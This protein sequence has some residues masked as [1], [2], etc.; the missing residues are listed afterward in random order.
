[1]WLTPGRPSL[2]SSSDIWNWPQPKEVSLG[3]KEIFFSF[4]RGQVINGNDT[5]FFWILQFCWRIVCVQHCVNFCCTTKSFSYTYAH[6]H[7]FSESFPKQVITEYWVE[8]P[9]LCI[10]KSLLTTHSACNSVHMPTPSSQSLPLG[11][12]EFI[13]NIWE[14]VSVLQINSFVSLLYLFFIF[15]FALFCLFRAAPMACVSSQARSLIWAIA[16]GLRPWPQQCQIWAM[17]VIYTT[18]HGNV[19][20]LTHWARPGLEPTT[21]WFLVRFF[22]AAPWW[23]LQF[24]LFLNHW[25][26][27]YTH[28]HTHT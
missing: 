6:I 13:F 23:E 2:S 27:L 17:S 16:A 21:S 14:S 25:V 12:H 5:I 8:F 11:N 7:S 24:W 22:S 4:V 18:A 9:G 10:S 3:F 28:I 20:S 15:I 1:M 19:G 26:C